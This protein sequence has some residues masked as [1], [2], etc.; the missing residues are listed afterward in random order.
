MTPAAVRDLAR[1]ARERGDEAVAAILDDRAEAEEVEAVAK[2]MHGVKEYTIRPWD[3]SSLGLKE[4]LRVQAVAA[5][6]HLRR[7]GWRPPESALRRWLRAEEVPVGASFRV[8]GV[9]A[10]AVWRREAD[11]FRAR[12]PDGRTSS[13]SCTGAEADQM[14]RNLRHAMEPSGLVEVVEVVEVPV[15]EGP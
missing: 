9:E 15:G 7:S 2:V 10:R 5:L 11:G 1:D 14:C 8:D 3:E 4:E 12:F 6:T 13:I